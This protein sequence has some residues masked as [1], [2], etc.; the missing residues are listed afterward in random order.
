MCIIHISRIQMI[1][2]LLGELKETLCVH[3]LIAVKFLCSNDV[4]QSESCCDPDS[5]ISYFTVL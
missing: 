5:K 2:H 1:L 3:R 4:C